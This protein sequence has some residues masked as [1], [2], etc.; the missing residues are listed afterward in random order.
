MPLLL[1]VF[2]RTGSPVSTLRRNVDG[3]I[4]RE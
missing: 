3:T 2:D 4:H 1:R